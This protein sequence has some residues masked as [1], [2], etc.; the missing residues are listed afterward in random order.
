MAVAE[1]GTLSLQRRGVCCTN[2]NDRLA[3][4]AA[5]SNQKSVAKAFTNINQC[6]D[7]TETTKNN[8]DLHN[9]SLNNF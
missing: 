6:L 5:V 8:D 4:T 2:I 1:G 9:K 7:P 3:K